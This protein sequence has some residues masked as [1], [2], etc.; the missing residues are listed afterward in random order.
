MGRSLAPRSPLCADTRCIARVLPYSS[1]A[2]PPPP[3]P[4]PEVVS[5]DAGD[6][7][8]RQRGYHAPADWWSLGVTLYECLVGH[9]PF[10][11]D[12]RATLLS[13]ILTQPV[14]TANAH[15]SPDATDFVLAVRARC[16]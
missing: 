9:R 8:R 4:A 11:S 7:D 16:E 1:G 10:R 2:G 14:T 12:D 3:L 15:L 13:Q 6:G 5:D